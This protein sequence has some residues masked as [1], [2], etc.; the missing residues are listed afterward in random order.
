MEKNRLIDLETRLTHQEYTLAELNEIVTE[1]ARAIDRLEAL[2]RTLAER[3]R[4]LAEGGG[5]DSPDDERPP[6]Y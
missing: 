1:Q 2:C 3:L 6:H 5:A 4:A